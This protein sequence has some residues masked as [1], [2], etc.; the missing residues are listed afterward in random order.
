MDVPEPVSKI[1]HPRVLYFKMS[2]IT[3]FT[4][5]WSISNHIME[6]FCD[7]TLLMVKEWF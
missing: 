7:W 6:N 5:I 1:S 4:G 2:H 3:T